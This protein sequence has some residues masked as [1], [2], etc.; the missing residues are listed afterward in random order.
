MMV[1]PRF[2]LFAGYL[3]MVRL[4]KVIDPKPMPAANDVTRIHDHLALTNHAF[5]ESAS[6]IKASCV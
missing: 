6:G 1:S 5:F 4:V 2:I 3:E